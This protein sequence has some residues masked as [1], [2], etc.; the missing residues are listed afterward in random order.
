MK[1]I[2]AEV[3]TIGD[4]ILYGQI[5]DTNTQWMS[6]N[7]DQ[8]GI[9]TLRKTSIGDDKS[10][11]LNIL[12]ESLERVDIVL[13]TGGL[14]PTKDDI[15]KTTLADFF[16]DSLVINSQ[17]ESFIKD[18]FEKRGRPFT[19]LNRQQAAIPSK[20]TYLHNATGTAPGMWFNKDGKIIVSMPGV[21]VEMKYLMT[22]EVIPRLKAQFE[23]PEIVHKVIRT[24]GLGESF[25]AEKI[26]NWEDNLPSH[27]KLAY[28]PN[29]GQ[30]KLRLTGIGNDREILKNEIEV[31]VEKLVLLIEQFIYST[32]NE[33][34]EEAIGNIL[35]HRNET[36]SVAESCTGGYLSH[37]FTSI[38]GSSAY[39][40]GGVVSYS[41]EAK[42]EVLK[43]KQETLT[44]FGAVSEQTII[45]MAEGV[46]KLLGT[47]YGI[48]T[49]G[50]AG[51]DG[52]TPEKP[53]GTV[54]IAVS[55]EQQTITKKLQLGK[56]RMVNIQ[57]SAKA[58]LDFLRI[59]TKG[60]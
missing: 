40:M 18:F 42:M 26:E 23:L 45:E 17:A 22:N 58:A 2:Y 10:E 12:K 13:I 47:T 36:V 52:G 16:D 50:I 48:A 7:L 44:K 55:N 60:K 37:L 5:T 3:I 8:I 20:C 53:V 33:E 59:L 28:L 51:P 21:P 4:E 43:V 41:N 19:E 38:A 34:I 11:I 32:E 39:F 29:F 31:E 6:E 30:V 9:K 27:I 14:G 49:S 57:Y 46:R 24:I 56:I 54:W 25:L 15:T 1:I 35:K